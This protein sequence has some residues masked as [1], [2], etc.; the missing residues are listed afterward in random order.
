ME[1]MPNTKIESG[2]QLFW[3]HTRGLMVTLAPH[4]TQQI[5]RA[6]NHKQ[7]LPRSISNILGMITRDP[8]LKKRYPN[9]SDGEVLMDSVDYDRREKLLAIAYEFCN[10]IVGTWREINPHKE[11]AVLLYGSVAKSLVKTPNHPQPSDI[12]LTV[13][14]DF[15][16]QERRELREKIHPMRDAIRERIVKSCPNITGAPPEDIR[17][18]GMMVQN[19][20]KLIKNHYSDAIHYIGSCITPLYDPLGIWSD[21]ENRAVE[22]VERKNNLVAAWQK[23]AA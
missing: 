16:E 23:M 2:Q 11:I 19:T 4:V 7:P 6:V 12:D 9:P 21:I 20:Q 10:H 13:I 22:F 8:I 3:V 5:N 18:A 15:S 17:Y 14:G 1:K